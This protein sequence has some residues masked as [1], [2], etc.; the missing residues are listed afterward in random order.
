MALVRR[1]ASHGEEQQSYQGSMSKLSVLSETKGKYQLAYTAHSIH[2]CKVCLTIHSSLKKGLLETQG[3]N[4][5][6]D[7]LFVLLRVPALV[8]GESD[9][10]KDGFIHV[11]VVTFAFGVQNRSREEE[12]ACEEIDGTDMDEEDPEK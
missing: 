5:N 10:G 12:P 11:G 9:I 2:T 3:V 1:Q 4:D 7:G 8:V 6:D